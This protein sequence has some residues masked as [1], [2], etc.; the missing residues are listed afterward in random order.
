MAKQ[1]QSKSEKGKAANSKDQ[2]AQKK[3]STAKTSV[4]P[5]G[6]GQDIDETDEQRERGSYQAQS[7]NFQEQEE[8][9]ASG[10]R[11]GADLDDP[12]N[13]KSWGGRTRLDNDEDMDVEGGT[14]KAQSRQGRDEEFLDDEDMRGN[15]TASH[16]QI[17]VENDNRYRSQGARNSSIVDDAEGQNRTTRA[18]QQT[19]PHS[20]NAE[21]D[22]GHR[23]ANRTQDQGRSSH[24]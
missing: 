14:A 9:G 19:K 5:R 7:R 15:R 10:T 22:Q 8:R 18:G 11:S 16:N 4:A 1:V 23:P 2:A 3:S 13:V 20:A 17:D 21:R 12:R 24:S 6:R